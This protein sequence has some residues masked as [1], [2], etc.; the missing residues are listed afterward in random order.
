MDNTL[1]PSD[2][3]KMNNRTFT[4]VNKDMYGTA[5]RRIV[6]MAD[7]RFPGATATSDIKKCKVNS[8]YHRMFQRK[9]QVHYHRCYLGSSSLMAPP[10]LE[11]PNNKKTKLGN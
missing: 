5:Y 3:R 7:P 8:G 1:K 4:S 10:E 9:P 2:I 6:E 11:E